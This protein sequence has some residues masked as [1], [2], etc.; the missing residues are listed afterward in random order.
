MLLTLASVM[1]VVV[2]NHLL[3]LVL[4]WTVSNL[5]LYRLL[6]F[7]AL[8]PAAMVAAHKQHMVATAAN[9]AML[10]AAVLL[11]GAFG[12]W[13]IDELLLRA[14][15]APELPLSAQVA[16]VLI[17]L[18]A[19]LKCAQLPFHGWLIQVM[20]A[21]TPVSALLHAGVVNLGGLVLVRL[22][23]L[24]AEVPLAM[25]LLVV[26]GGLTAA[27]AALVMTTRISVKVM[28]A[29][30][31]CAQMGFMLMQCGLGLWEM[32]LL[33][34]AG[35]SLYKAYAFLSA[36]GAVRQSQLRQLA[37]LPTQP[38]AS[39]WTLALLA[40]WVSTGVTM[41]VFATI[42]PLSPALSVMTGILTLAWLPLLLQRTRT[43]A[44][45]WS[46]LQAAA[47]AAALTATYFGLHLL[48]HGGVAPDAATPVLPLWWFVAALFAAL[49]LTQVALQAR[50][51]SAAAR[52]L[53]PWI[54]GGLFLDEWFSRCAMR[55]WP[56]PHL[57]TPATTTVH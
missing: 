52:R 14:V 48:L 45:A 33:H 43:M 19:I 5:G 38:D 34:L 50:P 44:G 8:R 51:D 35:H 37:P 18:A 6:T 11:H 23:P 3:W 1:L 7:F 27:I 49:F 55:H 40:A 47:A 20:E 25:A 30:S 53:Y 32:A 56:P 4:A 29:W 41:L 46:W 15:A 16:V 12:T 57:R 26:V 24:V 21:P 22:A 17:A 13:Q 54:Y 36:G 9:A 42:A 28:L 31:T 39:A 10:L 2:G